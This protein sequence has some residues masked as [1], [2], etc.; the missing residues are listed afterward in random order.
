MEKKD[1]VVYLVAA[2][3]A[4]KDD[5]R[6]RR[7]RLTEHLLQQTSTQRVA[8]I[9]PGMIRSHRRMSELPNG[10]FELVFPQIIPRLGSVMYFSRPIHRWLAGHVRTFLTQYPSARKVLWFTCPAF[11]GLIDIEGWDTVVYDCSDYWG[12]SWSERSSVQGAVQ[13]LYLR[14]RKQAED[15][16]L[17]RS[18]VVFATSGLLKEMVG[19]RTRTPVLVVENG[20]EFDRFYRALPTQNLMS[21]PRPRLGFLGGIKP[22]ID[23]SLL[24]ELAGQ[25]RDWSLVLMGPIAGDMSAVKEFRRLVDQENVHWIPGIRPDEVPAY[26][27]ELNVGLMPYRE[28]EYN[29]GVFPLKL[30]EYL[31]AGLPVV[32]CGLP[33]TEGYARDGIY[34]HTR[35]ETTAFAAA[36]EQAL[37]WADHA[38]ARASRISLARAADWRGKFDFML[39]TVMEASGRR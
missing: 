22:K 14:S 32:G 24:H 9:C 33:S 27:K 37:S 28:Q 39:A 3:S 2:P 30:F 13:R 31:A 18:D 20:V 35:A 26:L 23:F 29:R 1:S 19:G 25:H 7:H 36:C 10:L 11:P 17:E 12:R 16:I 15:Y 21:V 5:L 34:I 4:W 38:E 6:Y 8:W